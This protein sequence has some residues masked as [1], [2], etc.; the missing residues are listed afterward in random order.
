VTPI[1]TEC[2][3]GSTFDTD[4]VIRARNPAA[5]DR[6]SETRSAG[7]CVGCRP[8]PAENPGENSRLTTD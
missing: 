3:S 4:R 2:Y 8:V 1:T 7:S 5:G 6:E